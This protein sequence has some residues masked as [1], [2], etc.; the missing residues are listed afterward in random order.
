LNKKNFI[1]HDANLIA[2]ILT[3]SHRRKYPHIFN[4]II[5]NYLERERK[6]K[7]Q[8]ER[9]RERNRERYRGRRRRKWTEREKK[10]KK[11]RQR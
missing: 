2:E 7:K 8:R 3:I 6:K 5:K 10:R 1:G 9:E 4:H 11:N